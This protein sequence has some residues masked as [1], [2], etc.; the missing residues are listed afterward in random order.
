MKSL[1]YEML[2]GL[3]KKMKTII[4]KMAKN[5]NLSTIESKKQTKLMKNEDSIM[6]RVLMVAR[7]KGVVGECVKR[8]GD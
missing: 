1:L 3:K 6:D 7:W 2:K 5:T 8:R 4:N